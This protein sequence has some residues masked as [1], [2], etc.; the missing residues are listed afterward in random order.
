MTSQGSLNEI[1]DFFSAMEG[2]AV[3][4]K[5]VTS[6]HFVG[7]L[8]GAP[9]VRYFT[10]RAEMDYISSYQGIALLPSF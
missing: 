4:I 6:E 1:R 8:G 10:S 9:K 7:R 2:A 5:K 3:T